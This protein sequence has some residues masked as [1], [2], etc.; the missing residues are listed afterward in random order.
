[1]P[2]DALSDGSLP[3][4][5]LVYRIDRREIAYLSS[6]F[7]AYEDLGAVRTLDPVA[8]IIEIIYAP[9]CVHDVLAL[10]TALEAEVESLERI[11]TDQ[12]G[13]ES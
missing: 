3:L 4:G 7:E 11:V 13:E 1:M 5:P 6:L 12:K 2:G 9:D 10:M 8:A